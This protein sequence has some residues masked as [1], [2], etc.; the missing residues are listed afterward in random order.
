MSR[1]GD[2]PEAP[3]GDSGPRSTPLNEVSKAARTSVALPRTATEPVDGLHA[4]TGLDADL[5]DDAG[6]LSDAEVIQLEQIPKADETYRFVSVSIQRMASPAEQRRR[7]Q[8]DVELIEALRATQFAGRIFDLFCAEYA[9]Y[10]CNIMISLMRSGEIISRCA[11]MPAHRPRPLPISE[12]P[13]WSEEDIREMADE[14]VT[15]ALKVFVERALRQG[16]WDPNGPAS[17]R[18]YFVNCCILQYPNVF[19]RWRGQRKNWEDNSLLD[20]AECVSVSAETVT[21]RASSQWSDPTAAGALDAVVREEILGALKPRERII[22][23]L[24]ARGHSQVQIS[25]FL[26]LPVTT[27]RGVVDRVRNRARREADRWRA[28]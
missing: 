19:S 26:H 18:T 17:L 25:E 6:G 28:E 13:R 21:L 20:R 4:R 9:E 16:G 12:T 8:G 1:I 5:D 22:M 11:R 23:E 27:V 15:L 3:T 7:R 24:C 10:G 14:T 2:D